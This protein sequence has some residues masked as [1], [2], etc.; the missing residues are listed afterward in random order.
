[1]KKGLVNEDNYK[2]DV[3]FIYCATVEKHIKAGGEKKK[4]KKKK[5]KKKKQFGTFR[6]Q[7]LMFLSLDQWKRAA[8]LV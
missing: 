5:N 2:D 1:M 3:T 8:Q 4:Q 7:P 6:L